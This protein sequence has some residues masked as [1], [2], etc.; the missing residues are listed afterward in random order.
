M[1]REAVAAIA[2]RVGPFL[3]VVVWS[4]VNT[5][6]TIGQTEYLI[7]DPARQ[8]GL[9]APEQLAFVLGA[10]ATTIAQLSALLLLAVTLPPMR[11]PQLALR[12]GSRLRAV[13]TPMR[14]SVGAFTSGCVLWVA[15][16]VG[17]SRPLPWRDEWAATEGTAVLMDRSLPGFSSAE[18]S[19]VVL[20]V[21][22]VTSVAALYLCMA[23]WVGLLAMKF[24]RGTVRAT[25][26]GMMLVV[27]LERLWTDLLPR[28]LSPRHWSGDAAV[29]HDMNGALSSTVVVLV[30]AAIPALI[31]GGLDVRA[32][33]RV[34]GAVLM[35]GLS[36]LGVVVLVGRL[37]P[38][39]ENLASIQDA[40]R[41]GLG[42]ARRGTAA[43]DIATLVPA[44][45]LSLVPAVLAVMH[46]DRTASLW[47]M[48][49]V[50]GAATWRWLFRGYRDCLRWSVLVATA[51]VAV[52]ALGMLGVPSTA[53][54]ISGEG[55]GMLMHVLLIGVLQMALSAL[56]LLTIRLVTH[57]TWLLAVGLLVLVIAPLAS[58]SLFV[59]SGL[60]H[61]IVPYTYGPIAT[62]SSI[63]VLLIVTVAVFAVA[64]S[65]LRAS[66]VE[67]EV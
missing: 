52:L 53:T 51:P 56:V 49:A 48:L 36:V 45:T 18:V 40:F 23:T 13:F 30:L 24:S 10:P 60:H 55:V 20:I 9:T 4:W 22:M 7:G 37:W 17:L 57:S 26:I 19:P 21:M 58:G 38:P 28:Y 47:P 14:V 32:V 44:Q 59:P 8:S 6:G 54:S 62:V 41:Y 31:A 27:V 11:E 63:I 3:G 5:I 33:S 50:R 15:V 35:L 2:W 46:A 61:P 29:L 39:L 25:L 67:A 1:R 64:S 34:P 12:Q 66:S 42:G 43:D 16:A 65:V